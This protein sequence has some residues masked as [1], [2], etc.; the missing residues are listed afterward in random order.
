MPLLKPSRYKAAHGGRGGG[1]SHF[2]AEL[3][4]ERCVMQTTRAVC[5][6]EVQ[7]SIKDSARQLLI[8][9]INAMGRQGDFEVL[10]N[11]IRIPANDGLIIFRGM[12]HYNST[13]IK[14][15]EGYDIAWVM[16]AQDFSEDSLTALR[17]TLRKPGS[18]LW[19]EWNPDSPKDAVDKFFRG[20]N[21]PSD[22]IIVEVNWRDNPWFPD[23]LRQ[24][25]M[26]DRSADPERAANVWDGGYKAA[27]KGAYYAKLLALAFSD[28]RI[29]R[30]PH[31]NMLE[32]HVSFDLGNGPNMCAWF[33]QW[34][35]RE[36][37]FIDYLQGDEDARNEGWPWY[38]RKMRE[39]PYSYGRIILP[40]DA[41]PTQRSA[42][43]SDEAT[44]I[45][46][47]FRTQITERMDPDKRVKLVQR[48]LPICRFDADK[49]ATG[50]N[51]L[52]NYRVNY[53]DKLEI[54]RGP[55]HDWASHPADAFGHMFQAY[56]L[57]RT[58]EPKPYRPRY[59]GTAS[60]MA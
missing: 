1:K 19:F 55:L 28:G 16:E 46:A 23:V 9:K 60:W 30:E 49:C 59:Q 20:P 38:I 41:R 5:I 32:T 6:R 34:V 36:V 13:T 3:L 45:A 18:E 51:A 10:E 48:Y 8:D 25:M 22:A 24:E 31:D 47:G 58:D 52:R 42:G 50:L 27:P 33:A 4:I 56:E 29:G 26:D 35:G 12:Q 44:V 2:F 7:N 53:D 17:P 15:L 37:R 54:D 40:H 11:E 39:K 14:S 43:K 57:P 21:P